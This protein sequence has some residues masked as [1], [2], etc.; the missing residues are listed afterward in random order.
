MGDALKSNIQKNLEIHNITVAELERR[1]GLKS[2]AVRNILDGRSKNPN[3]ETL[4]AIAQEFNQNIDELTK[5]DDALAESPALNVNQYGFDHL[6][7]M[8]AYNELLNKA[9]Q[10]DI[11]IS[12]DEMLEYIKQVYEY[13]IECDLK[14]I[15]ERF[16]K[17]ILRK[18]IQDS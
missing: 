1:A 2:S 3:I 5:P 16:V 14:V 6:L 12:I 8:K 7:F 9:K 13:S 4:R 15:D 10:H 11:Q 18:K 17:Y